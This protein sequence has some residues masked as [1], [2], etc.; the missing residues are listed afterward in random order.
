MKRFLMLSLLLL[1]VTAFGQ[2]KPKGNPQS[3]VP[4]I[5]QKTIS[6]KTIS[7]KTI[8]PTQAQPHSRSASP[9]IEN[10][11]PRVGELTNSVFFADDVVVSSD[12]RDHTKPKLV[13]HSNGT[14]FATYINR[15]DSSFR[16]FRS[17]DNGT[18]WTVVNRNFAASFRFYDYDIVGIGID[19]IALAYVGRFSGDDIFNI[20]IFDGVTGAGI[21]S[22]GSETTT[23]RRSVAIAT[24]KQFPAAGTS[25]FG[26]A[27]VYSKSG[28]TDSLIY[29]ASS[30]AGATWGIR[31][32]VAQT[33]IFFNKV[34]LAYGRSALA[35][36]GRYTYAVEHQIGGADGRFGNIVSTYIAGIGVNALAFLAP[37][38]FLDSLVGAPGALRRPALASQFSET[39]NDSA[40]MT[41][42]LVADRLVGGAN[43]SVVSYTNK[44]AATANTF[45]N[46]TQWVT[47]NVVAA[48]GVQKQ[49]KVRY[50]PV[51]N[52][53]CATGFDS[54]T[55]RLP[56]LTTGRNSLADWTT[57]STSYNGDLT[58]ILNPEPHV[59]VNP[60]SGQSA[61]VWVRQNGALGQMLFDAQNRLSVSTASTVPPKAFKLEQNYPNPF[62]PSTEIRYQVSGASDVRLEVFD[63]LGRRV[64]T[65]VNERQSA[66]SYLATFNAASLA[67]GMY[68]YRIEVR[69]SGSQVRSSGSQAGNFVETKKMLLVK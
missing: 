61:H 58:G 30:D 6:Q 9:E 22:R 49:G 37:P 15:Q 11:I 36:A 23:S 63:M 66:G 44:R 31:R 38:V 48:P 8:S 46:P 7:Q 67:S 56:Y 65:L 41:T 33:T 21:S 64:A 45:A 28:L 5:E 62:N 14:V 4:L 27:C 17:T 69:S 39:N 35:S 42:V 60:V 57:V 32:A 34:A 47:R 1:T 53:F 19:T 54:T 25:P 52:N 3:A 55:G 18:S 20:S 68:F 51:N 2:D 10:P 13:V 16:A 40:N 12:P 43:V 50:D 26:I 24:D 59:E 29:V